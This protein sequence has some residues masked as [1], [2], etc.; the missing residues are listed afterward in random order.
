MRN[1]LLTIKFYLFYFKKID[2]PAKTINFEVLVPFLQISQSQVY[3]KTHYRACENKTE[4]KPN[5]RAVENIQENKE[6]IAVKII[7]KTKR[8]RRF[9]LSCS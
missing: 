9:E 2:F 4:L 1:P 7:S 6:R 8:E 5:E 3:N